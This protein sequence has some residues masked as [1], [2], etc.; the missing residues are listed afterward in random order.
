MRLSMTKAKKH[1]FAKLISAY[2]W[3][4]N[5]FEIL[6]H[7]TRSTV[8]AAKFNHWLMLSAAYCDQIKFQRPI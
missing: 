6:D 5:F 7:F 4:L 8:K 2:T 3:D 1:T